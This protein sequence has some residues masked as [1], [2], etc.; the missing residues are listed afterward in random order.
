MVLPHFGE[1]GGK[2]VVVPLLKKQ[3]IRAQ[4][5]E[6]QARI[7]SYAATTTTTTTTTTTSSSEET[8]MEQQ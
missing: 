2:R 5:A 6:F 1:G 3:I 4:T 7:H 8:K